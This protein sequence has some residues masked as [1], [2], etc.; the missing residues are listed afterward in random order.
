MRKSG[1]CSV[2]V[3]LAVAVGCWVLHVQVASLALLATATAG[4][5]S[6]APLA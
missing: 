6:L 3:F 2:C 5:A 1:L 4:V